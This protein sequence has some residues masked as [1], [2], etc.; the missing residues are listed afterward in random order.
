M[1]LPEM[2]GLARKFLLGS[3]ASGAKPERTATRGATATDQ[4]KICGTSPHQQAF[5]GAMEPLLT[6]ACTDRG[7]TALIRLRLEDLIGSTTGH[8]RLRH[9]VRGDGAKGRHLALI[10][11]ALHIPVP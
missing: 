1:L 10:D 7:R 3:R 6:H 8:F 11:P 2:F 9:P 4:T 5:Y